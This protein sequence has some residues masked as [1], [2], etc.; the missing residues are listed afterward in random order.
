MVQLLITIADYFKKMLKN[1]RAHHLVDVEW[2][3]GLLKDV[4]KRK[5]RTQ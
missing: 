4:E 1:S 3:K 5:N 2:F